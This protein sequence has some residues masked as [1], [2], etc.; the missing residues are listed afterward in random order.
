MW[1]GLFLNLKYLFYSVY[2]HGAI[3]AAE[4]LFYC[5]QLRIT[6]KTLV[7]QNKTVRN[8]DSVE[9]SRTSDGGHLSRKDKRLVR[10]KGKKSYFYIDYLT[11]F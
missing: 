3:C 2:Q 9:Q 10:A 8:V 4:A 5:V 1:D 11:L 6:H 7:T